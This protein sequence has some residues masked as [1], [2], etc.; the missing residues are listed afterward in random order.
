MVIYGNIHTGWWWLEPWNFEWLSR[1]SSE[2]NNDPNWRSPS[3]FRGVG[4]PPTRLECCLLMFPSGK[5]LHNYGKSQCL[6]GKSTIS[7]AIFNSKLL[8]Y[9]RVVGNFPT[10]WLCLKKT[11]NHP[12]VYHHEIRD[13]LSSGNTCYMNAAIQ[14]ADLRGWDV[15]S[16]KIGY[17]EVFVLMN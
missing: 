2:W 14:C 11:I 8:V 1:N 12:M 7:M 4:Q 13:G 6:M 9:Q 10:V 17:F 3:F 5:R 15:G 16:K